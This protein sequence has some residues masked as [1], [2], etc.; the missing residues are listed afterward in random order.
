MYLMRREAEEK[1]EL[2]AAHQEF[3]IWLHRPE[4]YNALYGDEHAPGTD[5]G[6]DEDFLFPETPEELERLFRD[7]KQAI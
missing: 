7:F 1:G 2:T 4:V 6:V 5:A 3:D